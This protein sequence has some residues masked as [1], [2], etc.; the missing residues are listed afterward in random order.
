MPG[1]DQPRLLKGAI[2]ALDP[3][4]PVASIVPFQYNPEQLSRSL[5]PLDQG[6]R[7]P[8]PVNAQR[9]T[10]PPTET[11]TLT[12]TLNAADQVLTAGFHPDRAGV[13]PQISALEMLLYPKAARVVRN[14]AKLALGVLEIVPPEAPLTLFIW[15][16]ARVVPV[17]LTAIEVLETMHDPNLT[18]I[19]ANLTLTLTVLTYQSFSPKN[20]GFSLYIVNQLAREAMATRASAMAASSVAGA[21]GTW[22]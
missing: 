20:P 22:F 2:V 18:P 9:L 15:G 19:A 1:E 8:S 12:V 3:A 17:K 11:I 13:Y 5:T 6:G 21:I 14:V 4:N 7:G 10:G 16:P